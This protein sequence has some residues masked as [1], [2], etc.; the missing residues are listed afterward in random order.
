[1]LDDDKDALPHSAFFMKSQLRVPVRPARSPAVR[2]ILAQVFERYGACLAA[3]EADVEAVTGTSEATSTLAKALL[4][5]IERGA[6]GLG[7]LNDLTKAAAKAKAPSAKAP[8]APAV[9]K[10][11]N[12]GQAR[13]APG[14][15]A[16]RVYQRTDTKTPGSRG[17]KW[18]R[19]K[20][21]KI[22]YGQ[23]PVEHTDLTDDEVREHIS[24]LVG[25]P[26]AFNKKDAAA[27]IKSLDHEGYKKLDKTTKDFIVDWYETLLPSMADTFGI[28]LD[29]LAKDP[30]ATFDLTALDGPADATF[31]DAIELY[32]SLIPFGDDDLVAEYEKKHGEEHAAKA[33]YDE[34][35][36]PQL[37]KLYDSFNS[38]IGS[39][40]AGSSAMSHAIHERARK[41]QLM[42]QDSYDSTSAEFEDVTANAAHMFLE[43]KATPD[44]EAN[45]KAASENVLSMLAAHSLVFI[46][47]TGETSGN[48]KRKGLAVV[49]VGLYESLRD[50]PDAY[51]QMNAGQLMMLAVADKLYNGYNSSTGQITVEAE[52]EP[53]EARDAILS[54]LQI[55]L[56]ADDALFSATKDKLDQTAAHVIARI[57]EANA[58]DPSQVAAIVH[59]TDRMRSTEGAAED[60]QRTEDLAALRQHGLLAKKKTEWTVAKSMAKG[61]LGAAHQKTPLPHQVGKEGPL[62]LFEPQK[63]CL[64]WM[65]AMERGLI[66]LDT[67]M[68]KTPTVISFLEHLK[69]NG[70][71]KRGIIILPPSLMN[72]W[73]GEI[74]NFA[75]DVPGS[76]VMNL[77]GFTREE[78]LKLLRSPQAQEVDYIII[79]SGILAGKGADDEEED[80]V[81]AGLSTDADDED[82]GVSSKKMKKPS[83]PDHEFLEA[84]N[85]IQDAALFIDEVHTGGYKTEGSVRQQSAAKIMEGRRYGFGLTATPMPN[86]A[87][88]LFTLTNIFATDVIG[89][90]SAWSAA[91]DG[92]KYDVQ[93]KDW[94]NITPERLTQL[95]EQIAPFM[96][97]SALH[98]DD[99]KAT[100]GKHIPEKF[101]DQ[102][103]KPILVGED[104]EIY[105]HIAPHGHA[106]KLARMIYVELLNRKIQANAPDD[107]LAKYIKAANLMRGGIRDN[108]YKQACI[109]PELY[110]PDYKSDDP[111]ESKG[112]PKL[113]KIVDDMIEHFT[114]GDG[115]EE[116]PILA[117]CTLPQKTFPILKRML[118]AKGMDPSLIGIVDG[119]KSADQRTFEQDMTNTGKRKILL[120][121]TKSGGAGLNLA[122]SS[123]RVMHINVPDTPADM[124]QSG[125]R[126]HRLGQKEH[127]IEGV[128]TMAAHGYSTHDQKTMRSVESKQAMVTAVTTDSDTNTKSPVFQDKQA[129]ALKKMGLN[130]EHSGEHTALD[131]AI[132]DARKDDDDKAVAAFLKRKENPAE[133]DNYILQQSQGATPRI[134]KLLA[135]LNTSE[136]EKFG[137][138]DSG[139]HISDDELR[140]KHLNTPEG[141][142]QQKELHKRA[143]GLAKVF[144]ESAARDVWTR[145]QQVINAESRWSQL[146]MLHSVATDGGN[147]KEIEQADRKLLQHA[148][149]CRDIKADL[150]SLANQA[151]AIKDKPAFER[152]SQQVEKFATANKPIFDYMAAHE[153]GSL[154]PAKAEKP[155]KAPKAA[156]PVKASKPAKAAPPAVLNVSVAKKHKIPAHEKVLLKIHTM[157][158]GAGVTTKLHDKAIDLYGKDLGLKARDM[159]DKDVRAVL[160]KDIKKMLKKYGALK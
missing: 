38:V 1:M 75:P 99:V 74:R 88:D 77:Q 50:N 48:R 94:E 104:H 45:A 15:A 25:G 37:K 111:R 54:A 53:S 83:E 21:G 17:G 119:T 120:I 145:N 91:F 35:V 128:Y 133:W 146:N 124:S 59:A 113:K 154:K 105:K 84:L 118:V 90:Q 79:S 63:R 131:Q 68:G 134:K 57:T 92:A 158:S 52:D 155:A 147:P 152:Y 28:K 82:G 11:N 117:L 150:E 27:L 142:R 87:D 89:S 43:D 42:N 36:A 8:P 136:L 9:P 159:A 22:R 16:Q 60:R 86:K 67:G 141:K 132:I 149:Q 121:G 10:L 73:P 102:N 18:Y 107:E 7:L 56:K 127:V 71:A 31:S 112:S 85:N 129:A 62:D 66:S 122:A 135:S 51:E 156:Q 33:I 110:D 115:T 41:V 49:N 30:T 40:D 123:H 65:L 109:S 2:D 138:N 108:L 137:R 139:G 3:V 95:K 70:L 64:N 32:F 116:S 151:K 39:D 19:D 126:A 5:D 130:P 96:F 26:F 106:D 76:K 47:K 29:D 14:T 93:K 80:K 6:L 78:R 140:T 13:A 148:R 69:E 61:K 97:A 101:E 153:R 72:Q 144:D 12:S 34:L 103:C 24:K 100:L 4:A 55:K 125:A 81:A 160:S 58:G 143:K 23:A 20:R 157:W 44:A 46:P 114:K 98:D